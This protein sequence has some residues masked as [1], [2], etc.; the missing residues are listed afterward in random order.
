MVPP[1]D[2]KHF[3]SKENPYSSGFLPGGGHGPAFDPRGLLLRAGD[4]ERNPGPE[5][6]QTC[7]KKLQANHFRCEESGCESRSHKMKK[8]SSLRRGQTGWRCREHRVEVEVKSCDHCASEIPTKSS[9]RVCCVADC[10]RICHRG[11]KCSKIGRYGKSVTQEWMCREH[12]GDPSPPDQPPAAAAARKTKLRCEGC[13]KTIKCNIDPINCARCE[14]SYHGSCSKLTTAMKDLIKEDPVANMWTC[15]KCVHKTE[16]AEEIAKTVSFDE[17]VDEVSSRA[18]TTCK[19]ALRIMQWNAESVSTKLFELSIRLKEDDIDVCLI[20]ESHLQEKSHVPYIEGYKL[21]RAD[22]VATVKG[23]LLAYVRKSLVVEE[24]GRVALDATEVSIFRIQLSKNKWLHISNVYVPPTTSK[25]QDV[26]KLRTDAIPCME[27][28]LICGDFNAHSVLWDSRIDP[29]Q[30]G[31][32]LVEWIFDNNLTVLNNGDATRIDRGSGNNSGNLS[33]PDVTLCGAD[34]MGKTEW[35]VVEPIGKSDHMPIVITINNDVK[36]QAVYG[37]KARWRSNGVEW[38]EFRQE[39]DSKMEGLNEISLMNRIVQ[40]NSTIIAAAKVHVRKVKPGKR[41][42]MYMSP[43]LRESIRKRNRLLGD[44]KNRREEWVQACTEVNEAIREAKQESW[45]EVLDEALADEDE[46]KLWTVAKQLNGTPDT[47]SPNEVL[48][49][50]GRRIT[51]HRKKADCFMNHYAN[52]SS[53]KFSEADKITNR[54]SKALLKHPAV[55]EKKACQNFSMKELQTAI[56]K[57]KRKGAPGP[58]D[59]PPSF[60]KELGPE[61][62]KV[63]LSIYNESFWNAACPQIWRTAI[64]VPLLKAGK[65]S[66]ALKSYRPV[67]LTSCVVKLMERL[68]AERI[69]HIMETGNRFSKLQA[70][71]RRGRSCED[72]ILKLTQAIENGFQMKKMERSVL[73][74]LDF[75]SAF[76]TVWRQR[77]LMSMSEQGIPLQIIRWIASFLDNRQA[78]VRFGDGMSKAR[79]MRQG[80]PQGSVLSPLLF[81]M[82]INNLAILLPESEMTSMFADDVSILS[83]RRSKEEA[84]RAAQKVVDIVVVWSKEWKLTLNST[85]SE[86]SFFTTWTHEAAWEPSIVAEGETIPFAKYP[87]L[88]GVYLDCQLS[89]HYH[90]KEAAAAAIKKLRLLAMVSYSTWGW[91]RAELMKLYSAFV[92]SKLD[93]AASSWQPWLSPSNVDVLDR[94]QNRAIRLITGQMQSSPVDALRLESGIPSYQTHIDRVCMRSVEKALRM[95]ADHPLHSVVNDAIPAKNMRF[96]WKYQ[97]DRL[98]ARVTPE[99][100]LR[101][102]ISFFGRAP[103][104][105]SPRINVHTDV[106]GVGGRNDSPAAKKDLTIKQI[107]SFNADLVIYTDGSATAG[108]REGGSGVVVTRGLAESPVVVEEIM[109]RGAVLTSS[110]EEEREAGETAVEWLNSHPDIDEDYRVVIATDSQSLCKAISMQSMGVDKILAGLATLPCEVIWQWVPGHSDIAGNEIADRVA[111]TAT[112]TAGS[113]RP[114]SLNAIY[115]EIKNLVPPEEP[116][117]ERSIAVYSKLSRTKDAEIVERKDQVNLARLRSGRHLGL[118]DTRHRFNP[119]VPATCDRCFHET[120]DLKHWLT[121]P[122]TEAAR[123]KLFG[124]TNVELHALTEKPRECLALAR[125]TLRGAGPAARR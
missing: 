71:F 102:P 88:L 121:C 120:D 60:L 68:V 115:A 123:M 1:L 94:V 81:I 124:Y 52:V 89:F 101:Q 30:R 57:M 45:K 4:V 63:L 116:T 26:I 106:P 5:M 55:G 7:Q 76:D 59:I 47:N 18:T 36:H 108:T 27:S 125:S 109:V 49:H 105:D 85:K 112:S 44:F 118:G 117:H 98:L 35:A 73:V 111:K 20:Q 15:Q 103:W 34:W 2:I 11:K 69:Y 17:H 48:I 10:E 64:I 50:Q 72:Q 33:T 6:C 12:R 53:L 75:S 110:Y 90:T 65:P 96:S 43:T 37:K 31:D 46:R 56:R 97:T 32:S 67:S 87:R 29:D 91:G 61:A 77:L 80:L 23:G 70:G 113:S 3:H 13:K 24:I 66:G 40:F 122:G 9:R 41:T 19:S 39:I 54:R 62:L 99:A 83:T 8:C 95:P 25:G 42:K 82:Y 21:I 79:I 51:S 93:Y 86:V 119:E 78:R 58:D 104:E 28:S 22:R 84:A 74:L 38:E 16:K 92:R 107:N 100:T 14:K 114:V